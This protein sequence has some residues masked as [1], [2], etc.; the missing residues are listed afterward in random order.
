MISMRPRDSVETERILKFV[1]LS[2]TCLK[3]WVAQYPCGYSLI[4]LFKI[5]GTPRT[6]L[7]APMCPCN[8]CK[9]PLQSPE[10]T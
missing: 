8:N 6:R 3:L 9:P 7:S 5:V 2:Y 4:P 10:V 1:K